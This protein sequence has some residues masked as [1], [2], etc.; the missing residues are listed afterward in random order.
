MDTQGQIWVFSLYVCMGFCSGFIYQFFS[1]LRLILGCRTGKH[2]Y[3]ESV[4]D[5]GFWIC[6]LIGTLLCAY[7][8]QLPT[9]RLYAWLGF[10]IGGII[11]LKSLRRMVA[12]LE[13]L[14]YNRYR[15]LRQKTKKRRNT[16]KKGG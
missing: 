2:V 3:L 5:V 10:L 8:L 9:T 16:P 11:Y 14:C 15:S 6:A 4:L 13:N 12:I 1:F 7:A